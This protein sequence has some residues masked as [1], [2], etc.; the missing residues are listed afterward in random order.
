MRYDGVIFDFDGT[1]ADTSE[2]VLS[3]VEYALKKLGRAVPSVEVLRGFIGPSLYD[4]FR[5]LIGLNHDE[6]ENAIVCYRE[7]YIQEGIY[8]LRLYDGM[9][10]LLSEL[11]ERGVKLSVASSKPLPQLK[12]AVEAIGLTS[13]FDIVIGPD[14]SVRTSDKSELFKQAQIAENSVI[15]G[16]AIFDMD[17]A[18]KVGLPA[19]A[20]AYGFGKREELLSSKPEFVVETVAELSKILL[21]K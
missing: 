10:E 8:K 21:D 13:L 1:L 7:R 12:I 18:H 20:A 3:C 9:K 4:S 15:V 14:P 17:G 19:I 11:K 16:D 5:K 2:G 6:A